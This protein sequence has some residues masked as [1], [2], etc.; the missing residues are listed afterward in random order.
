MMGEI[1]LESFVGL[2]LR[3]CRVR[4]GVLTGIHTRDDHPGRRYCLRHEGS[5]NATLEVAA[6]VFHQKLEV[7]SSSIL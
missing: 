1:M 4:G 6:S 5:K 3:S 7:P 2:R